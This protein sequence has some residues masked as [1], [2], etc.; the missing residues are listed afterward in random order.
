MADR[1]PT[2]PRSVQQR[3]AIAVPRAPEQAALREQQRQLLGVSQAADRVVQ[4]ALKQERQQAELA[5]EHAGATAPEQTLQQFSDRDPFTTY[6]RSAYDAAVRVSSA[7]I[8]TDA[9]MA[10]R[11]AHFEAVRDNQPPEELASRLASITAGLAKHWRLCLQRRA[12]S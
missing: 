5:G 9:L 3:A 12:Q 1:Y 11:E 10:M 2:T 6:E 7:R 8:S 4:F